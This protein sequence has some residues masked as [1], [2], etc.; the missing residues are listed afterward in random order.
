MRLFVA[1]PLPAEVRAALAEA[2]AGLRRSED[3]LRWTRPE[4][5]HLTVAFL[6]EVDD[7]RADEVTAVV[8]EAAV[9]HAP[10]ELSLGEAG[11]FGRR[12]LWAGVDDAPPGAVAALGADVQAALA[13]AELPV[14]RRGV[15]AHLTL[16]RA[17]RSAVSDATVAAVTV[18]DGRWVADTVS[19]WRSHLGRGP[20]RYEEVASV[21]LGA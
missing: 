17:G 8:T 18:P 13:A 2:T 19:V 10:V 16:A 3:G 7:H 14:A 15:H 1:L 6:G 11:R 21:A 4:G 5:W 9:A 12:V 20:A